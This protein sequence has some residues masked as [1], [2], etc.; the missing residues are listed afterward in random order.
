MLAEA[1][2]AVRATGVTAQL[3]I[4]GPVPDRGRDVASRIRRLLGPAVE[5]VGYASTAELATEYRSADAFCFPSLLEGFGMPILEAF[6]AGT[7]VV[8][9]DASSLPEVAGGAALVC[10]AADPRAWRDALLRLAADPGLGERLRVLGHQRVAAFSW[11]RTAGVVIG[12]LRCAG[13]GA[14]GD[15][16]P[17]PGP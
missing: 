10:P 14:G 17:A 9:S 16:V 3:R 6:A 8:I 11:D 12:A 7:P 13:A 15:R 4:V 1:V 5:L 2:L